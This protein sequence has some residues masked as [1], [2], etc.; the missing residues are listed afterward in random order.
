MGIE[1][2]KIYRRLDRLGKQTSPAEIRPIWNQ[3]IEDVADHYVRL[4]QEPELRH[5]SESDLKIARDIW[6]QYDRKEPWGPDGLVELM[7]QLPEWENPEENPE[8]PR[9]TPIPLRCILFHLGKSEEEI[10]A[11]R[12]W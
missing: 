1:R 2:S 3:Y 7:H 6:A 5:L 11:P 4:R 10:Q 8:G 12:A 9:S